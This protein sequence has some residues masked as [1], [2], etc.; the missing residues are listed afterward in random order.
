[1]SLLNTGRAGARPARFRPVLLALL[2]A[3]ST[4]ITAVAQGTPETGQPADCGTGAPEQWTA[5]MDAYVAAGEFPLVQTAGTDSVDSVL[6]EVPAIEF[7]GDGQSATLPVGPCQ[8]IYR[9]AYSDVTAPD[10]ADTPFPYVEVDWNTEGEPRGPNGSFSSPHFDFHFYLQPMA[11]I[12]HHLTCASTNGKTCDQF[13][14]S[15]E[16][17]RLFHLMPEA[18]YIPASYRPDVGSAIPAMGLHMLDASFEYTVENVNHSPI[19]I[20]G[21]FNGAVVF[22]EASVT[23]YTL[24]DVMAAPGQTISYPFA[25]PEAFATEIDWPTEFTITYLPDTGGFQAGFTT[26]V[27]HEATPAS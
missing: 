5:Q 11:D 12:D 14:T 6:V 9:F 24:Q 17:M 25:Q 20:Y 16:Q 1:V 10:G 18:Q 23:L 7:T 15:Y 3:G 22:A 8:T 27:H 21:T 13:E 26:F 4:V 2:I 19:L